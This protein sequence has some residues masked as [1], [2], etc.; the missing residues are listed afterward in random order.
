MNFMRR[1]CAVYALLCVNSLT[2]ADLGN[3]CPPVPKANYSEIPNSSKPVPKTKPV[4]KQSL[5]TAG[6]SHL[7]PRCLTEFWHTHDSKGN[8]AA[9]R[10]P[11]CGYG[12]VWNVNRYGPVKVGIT[13]PV[14]TLN[15][16]CPF[17]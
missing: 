8:A 1:L 10:C 17:G 7:C 14:P 9:H 13:N 2:A 4:V 12:P 15:P 3:G 11:Q 6:H 5:T 16:S